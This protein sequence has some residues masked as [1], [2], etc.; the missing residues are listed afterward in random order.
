MKKFVGVLSV[1]LLLLVLLPGTSEGQIRFGFKAKGGAAFIAGGDVNKA[2]EGFE[3]TMTTIFDLMA[4]PYEGGFDPISLGM[5]FGGEFLL[6]FTPN[7]GFGLGVE[8]LQAS[9]NSSIDLADPLAPEIT[10]MP[11]MGATAF[12]GSF[13]YFFPTSGMMKFYGKLGLGYYMAK[14]DFEHDW[15]FLVPFY[16]DAETT[17]GGLGFHGGLGLEYSLSPMFGIVAE[18]TGRY[19]AFKNFEG[20]LSWTSSIPG[21][22]LQ[23]GP[24]WA[25]DTDWLGMGNVRIL[26]IG[27]TEPAGDAQEAKVDFSGVSFTLGFVIHF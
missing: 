3:E 25:T 23:E 7:I 2:A 18:L 9:K 27:E 17:G 11:K 1:V 24:L 6:Q 12:T 20:S 14:F 19:A 15:W 5:N 21:E 8:F 10:W 26:W 13:Y 22:I 16:W 4:E